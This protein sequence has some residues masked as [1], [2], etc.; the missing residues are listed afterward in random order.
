MKTL[1]GVLV[2]AAVLALATNT[3]AQ[4]FITNGLVAY[5][6]FNG[7]ANDASG[8]G[9]NGTVVGARLTTDRFGTPNSAYN[10]SGSGSTYITAPDSPSLDVTS[11]ITIAV[12][13][14]SAGGGTYG[15]RIVS[16]GPPCYEMNV[17][18]TGSDT[19]ANF[20]IQTLQQISTH[21]YLDQ[22]NWIQLVGTYDGQV[23]SH[24]TNGTLAVQANVTGPIAVNNEPLA[25]GE[26]FDDNSDYFNGDIDDV[27]I[28]NRALSG[29]EVSQLYAIESQP[30]TN[31]P[32]ISTEPSDFYAT[33]NQSASFNVT[34][35]GSG[36]LSYQWL[37]NGTNLLNATNRT[38]NIALAK[39]AS[40]GQY[41]VVIT[42]AY[43]SVT[44]TVA[45]LLMFPYLSQPFVG[46]DTYWGQTNTLSVG[47]WGSGYLAYQWYFNGVPLDGATNFSLPLGAIQLTNAGQYSVVVSNA[48]GSVTNAPYSVVVNP[49]NVSLTVPPNVVIQG[50]VGYNYAV[51]STTNL[52]DSNSWVTETNITLTQPIQNW[53]DYGVDTRKSDHPQKFYQ[54]VP[55]Q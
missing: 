29:D 43:G 35:V 45:N 26:N 12:W 11:A 34:A 21:L 54:V 17:L 25:I 16:K 1:R 36:T 50:T 22:V 15:P 33:A 30:P 4:S 51:Q 27:R 28:Y 44:S 5:Y 19:M 32:S 39:Q 23:M 7:N 2:I 20:D 41:T 48:L 8:N 14:K 3:P 55:G 49:A 9:N 42:N 47:A 10:F 31:S 37:F 46:V 38:L 6:P 52:G 53:T 40:I 24:Y 13:I 18:G